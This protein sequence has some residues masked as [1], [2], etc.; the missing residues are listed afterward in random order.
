[1]PGQP[2]SVLATLAVAFVTEV[3]EEAIWGVQVLPHSGMESLSVS[4][5]HDAQSQRDCVF[6]CLTLLLLETGCR[7]IVQVGLGVI[8]LHCSLLSDGLP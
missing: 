1:M 6:F 3:I 7:S 8:I 4:L 5:V 2:T